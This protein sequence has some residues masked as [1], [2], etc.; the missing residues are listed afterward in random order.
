V[1]RLDRVLTFL[2]IAMLVTLAAMIITGAAW[3]DGL[4]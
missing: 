3:V 4:W 2:V 1:G